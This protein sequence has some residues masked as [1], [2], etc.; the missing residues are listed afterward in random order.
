MFNLI[1]L[2]N[3][4]ICEYQ[5]AF[6]HGFSLKVGFKL[7]AL[8]PKMPNWEALVCILQVEAV[9]MAQL[10]DSLL[11]LV[12]SRVSY[13]KQTPGVDIMC[14]RQLVEFVRENLI[15]SFESS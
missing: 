3:F 13:I 8:F 14:H 5:L 15:G 12:I 1:Q 4:N 2:N 9:I 7:L 10:H 11:I 6:I